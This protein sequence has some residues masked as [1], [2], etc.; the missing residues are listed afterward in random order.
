MFSGGGAAAHRRKGERGG[1]PQRR[2]LAAVHRV[3]VRQRGGGGPA[4]GER[5]RRQ[6]RQRGRAQPLHSCVSRCAN[7]ALQ[8]Q[9]RTRKISSELGCFARRRKIP[10]RSSGVL[11]GACYRL[12][13]CSLLAGRRPSTQRGWGGRLS[14]S[15]AIQ[16]GS[17]SCKPQLSWIRAAGANV[18]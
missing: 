5:R 14:G 11:Q 7:L 16:A 12:R 9:S 15:P 4:A 6:P 1:Q 17:L 8:T 3:P 18:A 2:L 10:L 13:S